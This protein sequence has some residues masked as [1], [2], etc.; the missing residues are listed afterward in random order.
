ME[1]E[2]IVVCVLAAVA[3]VLLTPPLVWHCKQKNVP[4]IFLIICFLIGDIMSFINSIIWGTED[5]ENTWDGVGYCDVIIKLEIG[6]RIGRVTATAAVALNLY[7]VLCANNSVFLLEKSW[8]KL[9]IELSICL[10]TPVFVMCTQYYIQYSRYVITPIT[11]CVAS[12]RHTAATIPL[13]YMWPLIWSVV[14]LVL[15]FMTTVKYFQ[16]RKDVS[17]ILKCTNSGLNLKRFARLL[18]F[19]LVIIAAVM[20]L[21]IY[22][23]ISNARMLSIPIP[24]EF[25]DRLVIY[26]MEHNGGSTYELYVVI[27]LSFVVF[28]L[29]GLGSDALTMYKGFICRITNKPTSMTQTELSRT[30]TQSR[31]NSNKSEVTAGSDLTKTSFFGEECK[32]NFDFES[33]TIDESLRF[34]ESQDDDIFKY[35]FQIESKCV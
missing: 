35:S 19:C 25:V 29:F 8:R 3:T 34:D 31:V 26:V 33:N 32:E 30:I 1:S 22:V 9:L 24:D 27:A 21:G 28:L 18:I 17:D 12:Y 14:A 11:G 7:M 10:I 20:P 15:A 2:A 13:Y 16:K 6:A 4:A 23:F 5:L